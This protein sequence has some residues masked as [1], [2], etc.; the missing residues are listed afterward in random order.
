MLLDTHR[1]LRWMCSFFFCEQV[2]MYILVS[3]LVWIH[4]LYS[5]RFI[6]WGMSWSLLCLGSLMLTRALHLFNCMAEALEHQE[7]LL[8]HRV[9]SALCFCASGIGNVLIL[10]IFSTLMSVP[11]AFYLLT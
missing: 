7:F 3:H 2:P 8:V 4:L 10:R 9:L 1:V 5:V 6:Y 11:R